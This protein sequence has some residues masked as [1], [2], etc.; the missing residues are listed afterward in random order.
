MSLN[1]LQMNS[2][3]KVVGL[4]PSLR[5]WG[6][7]VGSINLSKGIDSLEIQD[8]QVI[9]PVLPTGKVRQNTLD[10]LSASQLYYGAHKYIQGAYAVFVEVPV[11]SQSARAMVS[12]GICIGVLGALKSEGIPIIELT[13][14]QIKKVVGAKDTSKSEMIE[15]AYGLHPEAPWPTVTRLGETKIVE[16]KAEHMADA[17]AAIY[18]GV[19]SHEFQSLLRE[20]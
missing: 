17:T 10:I 3:V 11:G 20:S 14:N 18:A 8:L 15:W 4:D 1:N 16:G 7:S 19:A 12:Y 13:P 2:R 5:N 9:R 6:I